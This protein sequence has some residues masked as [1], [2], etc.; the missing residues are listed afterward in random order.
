MTLDKIYNMDCLEGMKSIKDKSI[1]LII[2]DPPYLHTKG[3]AYNKKTGKVYDDSKSALGGTSLSATNFIMSEMSRFGEEQIDSILKEF[4]RV[5]KIP[6]M[7]IFCNETQV[8]FYTMWATNHGLM[9]TILVWEKPLSIINRNRFSQNIEFI[10]RIYDYGTALNRL[11]E[12]TNV[13]NR[14]QK[15]SP[16]YDKIHPTQ[17]PLEIVRG[18]IML[19]SKPNDVILDAFMG[20]GT[21][22]VACV[23][24]NR[25]FIGFEMNP[26]YYRKANCRITAERSQQTLF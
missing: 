13:Y 17:K 15:A 7:Y 9:F 16:C 2:T 25:H 21:T 26:E 22:A 18:F 8:P 19:S 10:I 1:D 20:S 6:N 14:V 3:H 4:V 23:K 12:L 11:P 5:E 24:E